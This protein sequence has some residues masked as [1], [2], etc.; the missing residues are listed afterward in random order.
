MLRK[1]QMYIVSC[2]AVLLAAPGVVWAHAV[3]YP[4]TIN[5]NSY[6]KFTVRVPTEKETDTVKVRVEVPEGFAVS[7]VKPLPGWTYEMEKSAD[8][9]VVKAIIWSGGK[10]APGEF[11]EFEFQGKSAQ[12]PGKYAFPIHQTYAGGQTVAWTGPSDA[13]TPASVVEVQATGAAVDDHGQ[14]KP[15]AQVPNTP[16]PAPAPAPAAPAAPQGG[17]PITTTAAY[18]GVALG[19]V[20]LLVALRKR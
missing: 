14:Q 9:K 7:R 4:K 6:E 10:I 11:Q 8:G 5:A 17:S 2:I 15:A 3:V 18:A 13:Q 16:A 20:A 12:S 19:A 1:V